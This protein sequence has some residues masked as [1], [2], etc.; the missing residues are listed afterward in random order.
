MDQFD[1]Y[2]ALLQLAAKCPT[3]AALRKAMG[4]AG[5]GV[6]LDSPMSGYYRLRRGKD[7][8]FDPVGIWRE[9]DD[10][11]IWWG[12]EEARLEAVWPHSVWSPVPYDW[13]TAKLDG[14]EWPDIH[15][16]AAGQ[17]PLDA[18]EELVGRSPATNEATPGPGHNSGASVDE[19]RLLADSIDE[20]KRGVKQYV[21]ITSDE[22]RAL[23]QDLRSK[24]LKLS[25]DAKTRR[26]ELS[27]PHNAALKKIRATWSPLVDDAQNAADAVRNAQ[28]AWGT[29]KL[30]RQRLE[31]ARVAAENLK[32]EQ[33]AAALAEAAQAAIDQGEAPPE[34][35]YIAP[36]IVPERVAPQSSFKGGSGRAAHE[37]AVEVIKE[38][39]VTDW[40]ALFLYFISHDDAKVFMLK[41]ANAILKSHGE[42][43]PGCK[44]RT[45]AK[46]A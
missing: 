26:D 8:P 37:K 4:E 35:T 5:F 40:P 32:R 15:Q 34:P 44:T 25:G 12:T 10:L 28:E 45:V 29:L 22:Q 36:L 14:K 38:E 30:Q 16:L 1:D 17:E 23:S 31:E 41:K 46:V 24:L 33:E 19:V 20:A 6:N 42:V 18:V 13:Y 39:D 21:T 7:G 9:G 43:A 3:K 11:I 27:A 2:K